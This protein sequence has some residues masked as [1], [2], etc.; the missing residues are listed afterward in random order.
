M[1][2]ISSEAGYIVLVVL[3]TKECVFC[4]TDKN[5]D[6]TLIDEYKYWITR[7][8]LTQHTLGTILIISKEHKEGFSSVSFDELKELLEIIKEYEDKLTKLFKP[9]WFNYLQ[10]NNTVKHLHFHLIPRYKQ[11][12]IF[13]DVKFVDEQYGSM[14]KESKVP[15]SREFLSDLKEIIKHA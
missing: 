3:M 12:R 8:S 15:E 6:Y 1:D 14:V 7:I 4:D 5:L 10:T 9:D 2:I 11:E 13:R